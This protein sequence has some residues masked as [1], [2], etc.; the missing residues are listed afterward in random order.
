MKPTWTFWTFHTAA[1]REH[2]QDPGARCICRP[3]A[4]ANF[5]DFT[6]AGRDQFARAL[7]EGIRRAKDGAQ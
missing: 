3:P 7:R 5:R 4:V 1:C 2:L 6:A